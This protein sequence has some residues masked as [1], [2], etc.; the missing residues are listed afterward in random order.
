MIP[1]TNHSVARQPRPGA[2]FQ[3]DIYKEGGLTGA[4]ETGRKTIITPP[5]GQ[6][7]TPVQCLHRSPSNIVLKFWS[8][9]TTFWETVNKSIVVNNTMRH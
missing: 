5:Q 7:C 8:L 2:V 4:Q 1:C 3:F 6:V 9:I